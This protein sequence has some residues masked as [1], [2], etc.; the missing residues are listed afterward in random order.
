MNILLDL[1]GTILDSRARLHS[2]FCKL[3]PG[4]MPD[5]S[6]YW[7]HKRVPRSHRWILANVAGWD[8]GEI[9]A[10]EAEW[11]RKIEEPEYL[12]L[13]ELAPGAFDAIR[14]LSTHA[15]VHLL[16]AR[17]SPGNLK[18]Q[19]EQLGLLNCFTSIMATGAGRS[20]VETVRAHAIALEA[21]DVLVGDTGEDVEA[22]RS[23]GLVSVAIC[24][25]FR[26]EQYL[27]ERGAD[28]L[29]PSLH[30]FASRHFFAPQAPRERQEKT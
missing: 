30:D 24:S 26:C 6:V 11:L 8:E 2:L 27:R 4:V 7:E 3:A 16:T 12:A 17:R 29:Y 21:S 5:R 9:Q 22:A 28:R 18:R 23:L 19:L 20:K 25:G 14:S 15:S 13:D 1:D 10:F